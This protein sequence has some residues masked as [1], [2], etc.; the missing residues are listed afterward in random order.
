MQVKIKKTH[1]NAVIPSY[2]KYGDAALDLTAVDFHTDEQGN[3]VYDT[4]IAL[5]IPKG[6]VGLVFPR[7]SIADKELLL[8]N[9]VGVIDSGYRGS[10][11]A[12]FKPTNNTN[13]NIYNIGDRIA[14]LIILPYP[15]INFEEVEKLS[16]TERG[17]KG[18]GSTNK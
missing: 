9:S 11:K 14:Q 18:Y 10:I 1:K 7:S 13:P 2:A 15:Q 3:Y 16:E 4:G 6:Y 12:K 17:N 5:E 8:T